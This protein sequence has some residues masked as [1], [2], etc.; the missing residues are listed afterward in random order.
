[1]SN[2]YDQHSAAFASVNAYVVVKNGERV[3]TIAF[4]HPRDGAGKLYAYVHWIGLQMVR[5][6][7]SGGGYDKHSAAA[8][9]AV[10][11]IPV[12]TGL[13]CNAF[14]EALSHDDGKRWVPA[15]C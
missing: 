12:V 13:D 4:K 11:Q 15:S 10:K 6:W 5:G 8:S 7:A 3:A 14:V 1:M 9:V 2:I